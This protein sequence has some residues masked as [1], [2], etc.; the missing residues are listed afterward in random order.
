M[1]SALLSLILSFIGYSIHNI[2]QAGQKIGLAYA[3][4]S[5]L[6][7]TAIWILASAGTTVATFLLLYAVTL[8][9]VALVGAMGGSGLASLA[10][11]SHW[12]MK[13][14]IGRRELAGV[15]VIFG[16]AAMIGAF[17]HAIKAVFFQPL[18]LF[19]FLAVVCTVYILAWVI[20]SRRKGSVGIVIAGFSGALGGVVPLF[21]KVSTSEYGRSRSLLEL[22]FQ[23]TG[24]FV[25]LIQRGAE[26][27]SNPYALLWMGISVIS[28]IIMQFSYRRD[29]AIRLVPAFASNYIAVPVIG[30][31]I[32]FGERLHPV[33]WAGIALI[34]V[35]VLLLTLKK[36]SREAGEPAGRASSRAGN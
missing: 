24:H 16:A 15:G 17:H 21:Q 26:I 20:L 10:L 23:S 25:R 28:M 14:P 13:E 36:Q 2:G 22:E 5:W 7:G 6:A 3:R 9:S 4:R 12:V 34:V 31:L 29:T 18:V 27:L 33:Q 11:F 8:G 1:A 19:L 30:A 35:G 32:V